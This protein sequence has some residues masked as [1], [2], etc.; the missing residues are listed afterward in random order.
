METG[1]EREP[2]ASITFARFSAV[3]HNHANNKSWRHVSV[4]RTLWKSYTLEKLASRHSG[5]DISMDR[6]ASTCACART[7][8]CA[9]V[10]VSE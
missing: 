8:A 6:G 10:C 4:T 7:I 5:G 9:R 3:R 1:G 2:A